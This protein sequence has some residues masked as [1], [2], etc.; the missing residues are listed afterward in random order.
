[1]ITQ[2][3]YICIYIHTHTHTYIYIYVYT[4]WKKHSRKISLQCIS[5]IK[6]LKYYK[7]WDLRC[8]VFEVNLSFTWR[9]ASRQNHGTSYLQ[10]DK[11][12]STTAQYLLQNV[13]ER[14]WAKTTSLSHSQWQIFN[15]LR[16]NSFQKITDIFNRSTCQIETHYSVPD[17]PSPIKRNRWSCL[18]I[19]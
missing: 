13:M 8:S 7:K 14:H 3:I 2:D 9:K 16:Q 18:R 6:N 10:Q 1:M 15:Q 17:E 19:V 5:L 12:L 11:S 4:R